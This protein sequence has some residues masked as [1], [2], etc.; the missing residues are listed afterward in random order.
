MI[1]KWI[2]PPEHTNEKAGFRSENEF[3][4]LCT[5]RDII[6]RVFSVLPKHHFPYGHK[7]GGHD[8]T[9]YRTLG[10]NET[11]DRYEHQYSYSRP[12]LSRF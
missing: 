4:W 10:E 7:Y 1:S 6:A 5:I 3:V 12:T 9:S 11:I 8:I 2:M